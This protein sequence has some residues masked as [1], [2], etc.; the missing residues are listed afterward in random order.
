MKVIDRRQFSSRKPKSR[1]MPKW[2]TFTLIGIG[3]CAGLFA[4]ANIGMALA[5]RHK[6][7]PNYS[8]AG[9]SVGN[10]PFDTLDDKVSATKLLPAK[11]VLVKGD[12]NREVAP[13]D[14]GVT[15][16]WPATR[17]AIESV[18]P[19][20]PVLSLFTKRSVAA[21]L[22]VDSNTFAASTDG[23][24]TFFTKAPQ[25]QHIVFRNDSFAIAEP[26]AGYVLDAA[27]F[28]ADLLGALEQGRS[29]VTV[30]TNAVTAS[31]SGSLDSELV[32]L[33]K[34]LDAK[35][36]LVHA[37]QSRQL[38]RAEIGQ[39]YEQSGQTMKASEMQIA[40]VIDGVAAS[41]NLTPV[42][43]SEAVRAATYALDKSQPVTFALAPQGT[44]VY[45]YCTAV[46]GVNASALPEYRQK[47]AAVYGDPQGWSQAGITFVY[48]E[49]G[50]NYTA[51]LSAPEYMT[52]FGSICDNYYSCRVGTNVVVN[53]DRWMGATDP[54]NQAG[55]TLEDYR[56]M[57]INHES[58]HW[59][60]F[61]HRMCPGAG[62][63]APVMQQQSISLQGCTFN[64]WPTTAEIAALK[65]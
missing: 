26:E 11:V 41:F 59:L 37:A 56:V 30:P 61:D 14:V 31:S 23:L 15:I 4:L 44:K 65:D 1:V 2:A 51:W 48:A 12:K 42:N 22:T 3:A 20:L 28:R 6:V 19:I 54:W 16:D 35:I 45:R 7:L 43:A 9:V 49:S 60:G 5:Y 25:L 21:H 40:K 50:C 32:V 47:L 10:L 63:P 18:R 53:Y 33:Q 36:T 64:P 46:K 29:S 62:Q 13:A 58:G 24:T 8:V 39:F 57:V 27:R 38:S 34:H 17:E 52:G 55:G